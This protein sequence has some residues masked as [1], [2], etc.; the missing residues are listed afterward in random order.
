MKE[1]TRREVVR[2]S[3]EFL[4]YGLTIAA[5]T[6]LFGYLG[7]LAGRKLGAEEVLTL[8]GGLI[9]AAA[10]F[11]SLYLHVVVRTRETQDEEEESE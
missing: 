2:L 5:S 9:G 1:D 8:L 11:Y 3:S 7:S 10:G 4:G 6:L